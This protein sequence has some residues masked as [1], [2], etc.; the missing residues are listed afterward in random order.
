[1][2]EPTVEPARPDNEN[3]T[4]RPNLVASATSRAGG[5]GVTLRVS[6]GTSLRRTRDL[7]SLLLPSL[8][9]PLRDR[10]LM[11]ELLGDLSSKRGLDNLTRP[12]LEPAHEPV[13]G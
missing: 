2:E 10:R 6:L 3:A 12:T 13:A 7:Q 8:P 4:R 9:G 1:M 11:L 5:P